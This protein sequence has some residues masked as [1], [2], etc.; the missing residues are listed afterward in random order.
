[1]DKEHL[2]KDSITKN[3]DDTLT[4]LGYSRTR[5]HKGALEY[6]NSKNILKF[7]FEWNR[8]YSFYCQLEFAGEQIDYPLSIV[9]NRLKN[10]I[11]T[12]SP[13]LGTE[14][15]ERVNKWTEELKNDIPEFGI[16][17]LTKSSE[18]I[19]KLK[20]EIEQQ[21]LEYNQQLQLEAVK[22]TADEAWNSKN[23]PIYI[24]AV[25]G[26]L[27]QL[28]PSYSKKLEIAKNQIMKKNGL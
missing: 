15:G 19:Y 22:R 12:K 10:P 8:D 27:G 13:E 23:Y 3:L 21:S 24:N 11:E 18:V 2:F 25:S 28:P 9:I 17:L 5:E 20:K 16:N 6:R 4:G 14:F 7:V 26:I 1:M